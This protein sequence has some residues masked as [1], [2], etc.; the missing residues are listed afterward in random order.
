MGSV[1]ALSNATI[2][3]FKISTHTLRGE[4]DLL[5]PQ[6]LQSYAISTH[7][8]RGERDEIDDYFTAMGIDFNSHA[9]RGA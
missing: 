1:T 3:P 6:E 2:S 5:P 8:L 4:R 7:T 9:P